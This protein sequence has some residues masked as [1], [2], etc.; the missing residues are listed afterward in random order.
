LLAPN[1]LLHMEFT[2]QKIA[3]QL[4]NDGARVQAALRKEAP[5]K[6]PMTHKY[7]Y[8]IAVTDS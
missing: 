1:T 8:C 5:K 2:A 4:S 3:K 7:S 6:A